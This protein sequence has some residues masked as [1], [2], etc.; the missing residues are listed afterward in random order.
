M[1]DDKASKAEFDAQ[2]QDLK[3]RF[4]LGMRDAQRKIDALVEQME[5]G[6][7][8]HLEAL[9]VVSRRRV[10]LLEIAIDKACEQISIFK[11]AAFPFVQAT[12][13]SPAMIKKDLMDY[14]DK[15]YQEIYG[16][17]ESGNKET[18]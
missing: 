6:R 18:S 8:K 17:I 2:L 14:A 7:D 5:Q 16:D 9:L 1:N 13:P 11:Q 10:N 15:R 3:R 12:P 4:D